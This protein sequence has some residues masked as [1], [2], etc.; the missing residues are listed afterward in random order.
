MMIYFDMDGVLVRYDR[1]AY[2]GS[3]PVFK[4]LGAH[5]FRTQPADERMLQA[6][7]KLVNIAAESDDVNVRVLSSLVNTGSLFLEQYRDKQAWLKE[8]APD[9]DPSGFVPAITDK[10][11]V[12]EFLTGRSLTVNDVLIDDYNKNLE[13]WREHGGLAVKYLN[14]INSADSFSGPIIDQMMSADDIVDMLLAIRYV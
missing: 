3:E 1:S 12:A 9:F 7:C 13:D 10:R 2:T 6:F 14:G 11:S 8:H 4:K 5:Y